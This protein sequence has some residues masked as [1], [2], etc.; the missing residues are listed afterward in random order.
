[1]DKEIIII[2]VV[3]IMVIAALIQ[4]FLL[5]RAGIPTMKMR[6]STEYLQIREKGYKSR[7]RRLRSRLFVSLILFTGLLPTSVWVTIMAMGD[8]AN[9]PYNFVTRQ[10]DVLWWLPLATLVSVSGTVT[11]LVVLLGTLRRLKA[12]EAARTYAE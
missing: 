6:E 2:F 12:L 1:M 4:S 5:I 11:A 8:L 7:K 9:A 10:V 3:A